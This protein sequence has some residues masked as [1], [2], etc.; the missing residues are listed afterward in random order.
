MDK[1][2]NKHFKKEEKLVVNDYA[3]IYYTKSII[4]KMKMKATV[5]YYATQM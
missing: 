5:K 2:W 4:R 1:L 3:K